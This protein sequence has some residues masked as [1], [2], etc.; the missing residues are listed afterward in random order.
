MKATRRVYV[1]AEAGVN[2]DGSVT[3]AI[4]MIDA[5]AEAGA[6]AVK[7]QIFKAESVVTERA[8]KAAY[9]ASA[10][11]RSE[12]Q[13]KMLKR[14]ELEEEAYFA[15]MDRCRHREIDFLA[16]PF[17][18]AS[19]EFLTM[20]LDASKI[21]LAS[22]EITNAPL[23]LQAAR[24]GKEIL[25]STGM[26][27]TAEVEAAL[28]VLAFG[29]LRQGGDPSR[30]R[31][32][33][34]YGSEAGRRVIREKVTV[35]HCTSEYPAPFSDVNLLAMDTLRSVFA[36]KVGLSDHTPG[37]AVAI[38]AAARSADVIEKH[39]T[40]DRRLPGPDHAASLEPQELTSMITAIRQVEAALG[41]REKVLTP[42]EATNL[43]VVRRSI[44]A[45][46]D[47]RRGEVLSELNLA[48]KR[49]AEGVSPI[50]YWD[51]L[52]HEAA[53]DYRKDEAIDGDAVMAAT[54]RGAE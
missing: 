8:T 45:A 27:T 11:G 9:Q 47:I 41:S 25:L 7:F 52:G 13:Y 1:I 15:L 5:A 40:L 36:T 38:A 19:L 6:D 48:I 49:P 34:A 22:G 26:S 12:T 29:Y 54:Q 14:L 42:S 30:E 33:A 23:L 17:D 46:R 4:E 50:F 20:A 37:Y 31:F 3:R 39:F 10:T 21:K 53:R 35:L 16:S 32:S 2:H 24:S 18:P 43:H 28:G 44:V 51:V